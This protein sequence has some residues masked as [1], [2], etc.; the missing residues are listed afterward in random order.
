[1]DVDYSKKYMG[2]ND[3]SLSPAQEYIGSPFILVVQATNDT[4]KYTATIFIQQVYKG[5]HEEHPRRAHRKGIKFDPY[6]P[7][8]LKC[9]KLFEVE[10]QINPIF[11]IYDELVKR[12]ENNFG[13]PVDGQFLRIYV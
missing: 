9:P 4:D 7:I 5:S 12:R 13:G 3:V 8:K 6:L 10:D 1:M 2:E 11:L